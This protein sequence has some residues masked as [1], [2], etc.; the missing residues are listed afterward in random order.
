MLA[1]AQMNREPW[2]VLNAQELTDILV[3]LR[4][5][6]FPP[7][8]P[9]VFRIGAGLDGEAV[10]R[11]RSCGGCHPS[12]KDLSNSMRAKTLT[13]VAAAMWNHEPIMSKA[14]ATRTTFAP[15]E[16]RELLGFL[17]AQQFFEDVGTA[18]VGR[19]SLRIQAVR[20]LSRKSFRESTKL[21][22]AGGFN[23]ATMASAL[24]RHGPSMLAQMKSQG[25]CLAAI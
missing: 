17:W 2:P 23:G 25:R 3:Y 6:P 14:G 8:R 12:V 7:S 4:N 18:S 13:E 20:F 24:W 5:L 11:A 19:A 10:F 15:D 21:T 1:E 9:P 22:G 16:M